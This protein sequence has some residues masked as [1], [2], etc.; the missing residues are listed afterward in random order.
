MYTQHCFLPWA[1]TSK[2]ISVWDV[3]HLE[4]VCYSTTNH[5]VIMGRAKNIFAVWHG[6]NY[7][8]CTWTPLLS[9]MSALSLLKQ[10]GLHVPKPYCHPM[11]PVTRPAGWPLAWHHR[12]GLCVGSVQV[13]QGVCDMSVVALSRPQFPVAVV[14]SLRSW[15]SVWDIPAQKSFLCQLPV[16]FVC[17]CVCVWILC[18]CVCV[19]V[20]VRAF[21][22]VCMRACAYVRAWSE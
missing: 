22:C 18:V 20:C 14:Q 17:V 16:N 3:Q 9:Y 12:R 4:K 13:V 11:L 5:L 2:W 1:L 15:I 19:C 7:C 8:P 21:V 6:L 10:Q